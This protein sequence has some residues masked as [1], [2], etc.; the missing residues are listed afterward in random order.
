[1]YNKL[2]ISAGGG[3]ISRSQQSEQAEAATVAIGLGGTGISCLREL[4]KEVF[5]KLKPDPENKEIPTYSHIKFLALD[6]D[7]G[8]LGDTGSIDTI[9]SNTEFFNISCPDI[10]GLL[11]RV[12]TLKNEPY[13][14][15]L[16]TADVQK[17]QAG[18]SILNAS[19]GAGGVRQIGR[20]LLLQS[21]RKF[22]QTL[23]SLIVS[24]KAGL[25]GDAALNI[26]IFTGMGGGTGAGT[27]MD[28]CYLV[29]YVL[30]KMGLYGQAQ[31]CGFFFL[32]D[33]NESKVSST[34]VKEYIKINGF[35]AMKELDYSMN[36]A[37]NGGV[38]EQVYDGFSVKSTDAPVKLAHLITAT[39]ADG[40]IRRNGYDYAMHVAVDYVLE[41]LTKPYIATGEN[42]TDGIFTIES[43]ISNVKRSVEMVQK[44]YGACYD[45]CVLGA[46][47]TYLPYKEITTYLTS[48]IF[49]GFNYLNTC[50]ATANDL[51]LFIQNAGLKSEDIQ[52][53]LR[54]RVPTV[55]NYAVDTRT[56]YDQCNGITSEVI[57]QVLCQMRDSIPRISGAVEANK[58]SL[59]QEVETP[60][61]DDLKSITSLISRIKKSLQIISCNPA[62]GPYFAASLLHSVNAKDLQN[63]VDGYIKKNDE[64]LAYARADLTLRDEAMATTLR[65]FQNSNALNRRKRGEHYVAA[66][67]NYFLKETQIDFYV[68]MGDLLAKFKK[69]LEDLYNNYFKKFT[70]VLDNLTATF[71]ANLATLSSPLKDV[72]TYAKPLM[73]IA[74]L[75]ESLDKSVAEMRIPDIV[76]HFVAAMLDDESAWISQDEN[77]ISAA[78]TKFFLSE[79]D[80][81]THMTIVDYLQIRF[82]TTDPAQ[83]RK[84][85][86]D[87][88]MLPQYKEANPLFWADGSN[89]SISDASKIGYCSVPEISPEIQAAADDVTAF[90]E[91]IS[92]RVMESTDRISIFEFLCGVPMFGYK[93]VAN[94][95]PEYDA[96]KM[97]GAH[98]YECTSQDDRD[99]RRLPD[100]APYSSIAADKHTSTQEDAAN[101][102]DFALE[103]GII[104]SN[105]LNEYRIYLFDENAVRALIATIEAVIKT[106]D[107]IKANNVLTEMKEK[108]LPVLEKETR[109]I[110]NDAATGYQEQSV[111]DNVIASMYL[112]SLVKQQNAILK[113]YQEAVKTLESMINKTGEGDKLIGG[114][115]NAL[116]SGVI[117]RDATNIF[118]YTYTKVEYGVEEAVELTNISSE[119]YGE[120][121]PLY[122][123]F[124]AYEALDDETKDAL[125]EAVK[126]KKMADYAAVAQITQSIKQLV[127]EQTQQIINI[128]RQKYPLEFERIDKFIKKLNAELSVM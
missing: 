100:V 28:V 16:A 8:S 68:A 24:A 108:I 58:K 105:D 122:S 40:A 43:H 75:K 79:L 121:L 26:H 86:Y 127:T 110:S 66:V 18:L 101:A 21:S 115:A 3:I 107:V 5:N 57:P 106:G 59:L 11:E 124:V 47:N 32:P 37:T 23:E 126:Q 9:D 104:Q 31:T 61:I 71:N 76:N 116:C 25:P 113:D 27:F 114:F 52:R 118:L 42:A 30:K 87:E 13:L 46:S 65:E 39:A 99:F 102:Y 82:D 7:S 77:K 14:K 22:T 62:H 81:Y 64:Q 54:A 49:E 6:T 12:T 93:G 48:K 51:S 125:G 29:Q 60:N 74:D 72:E 70:S 85:I 103:N 73:T 91:K 111:K 15:W 20:L 123:A 34:E 96:K 35:A 112:T 44:K 50:S 63:E 67:H 128:A 36:Y 88:I 53:E 119:P 117:S 97:K 90:D 45:Y 55:P 120:S 80:A 92:R 98:L 94:Y 41:F 109:F 89:Y 4:K 69:Q 2:L 10:I 84:K 19:A 33:V 17:G 56:L 95:F 78:V 83:L 38:W 1:M